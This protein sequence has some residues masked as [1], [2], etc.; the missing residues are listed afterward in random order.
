[1]SLG[2]FRFTFSTPIY[3]TNIKNVKQM[4]ITSNNVVKIWDS[5]NDASK[6]FSTKNNSSEKAIKANIS[7]CVRKFFQ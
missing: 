3:D 5:M 1:M 4:G 6:Y 2:V 7:Q